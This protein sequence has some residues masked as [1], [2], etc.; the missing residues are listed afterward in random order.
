M[1]RSPILVAGSTGLPG[2]ETVQ[3]ICA[4]SRA[5][6]ALTRHGSD[7][8]HTAAVERVEQVVVRRTRAP[9]VK[10][11]HADEQLVARLAAAAT[12]KPGLLVS[13]GKL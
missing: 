6:R 9:F 11:I 12:P 1:S 8:A 2:R 3:E 7:P 4:A 5:E 10:A 13:P